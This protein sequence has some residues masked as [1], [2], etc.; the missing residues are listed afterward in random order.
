VAFFLSPS[1]WHYKILAA[2]DNSVAKRVE[3]TRS[4]DNRII[5]EEEEEMLFITQK[6]K[7]LNNRLI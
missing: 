3:I 1:G 6:K 2:F 7:K 4:T 5:E